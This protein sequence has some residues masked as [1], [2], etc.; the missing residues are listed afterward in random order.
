M[1]HVIATAPV[2]IGWGGSCSPC[3]ALDK[4]PR[5]PEFGA[6]FVHVELGAGPRPAEPPEQAEN[7]REAPGNLAESRRCCRGAAPLISECRCRAE[8]AAVRAR[9]VFCA[10]LKT[11]PQTSRSKSVKSPPPTGKHAVL[12]LHGIGSATFHG[13]GEPKNRHFPGARTLVAALFGYKLLCN[14][15]RSTDFPSSRLHIT[16]TTMIYRIPGI[17]SSLREVLLPIYSALARPQ[18]GVYCP[19]LGSPVQETHGHIEESPVKG[20]KDA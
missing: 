16:E 6:I 2:P 12:S 4:T 17:A 8:R 7:H 14:A 19:V 13:H 1:V 10:G 3:P 5:L 15:S 18:P 9:T 11:G 20:Q